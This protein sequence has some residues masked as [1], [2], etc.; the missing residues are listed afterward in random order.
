MSQESD[1][2]QCFSLKNTNSY[3]KLYIINLA[4]KGNSSWQ[5]NAK[6]TSNKSQ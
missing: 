2:L 3:K 6:F 5:C 1:F 4:A